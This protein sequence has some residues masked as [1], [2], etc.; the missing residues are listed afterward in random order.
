MMIC[1]EEDCAPSSSPMPVGCVFDD[2]ISSRSSIKAKLYKNKSN[3]TM[4]KARDDIG[5]LCP[6]SLEMPVRLEDEAY[7]TPQNHQRTSPISCS[8]H[9]RD[10]VHYEST[11]Q[12]TIPNR[13]SRSFHSSVSSDVTEEPINDYF[14][15]VADAVVVNDPE[16]YDAELMD[17]EE[18]SSNDETRAPHIYIN[19]MY[20]LP[21]DKSRLKRKGWQDSKF[22][23]TALILIAVSVGCG[24]ITTGVIL[25]LKE[26]AS[27]T[28]TTNNTT[29]SSINSQSTIDNHSQTY[30]VIFSNTT[31]HY[32]IEYKNLTA[33]VGP[34]LPACPNVS[35]VYPDLATARSAF[36]SSTSQY[37]TITNARSTTAGFNSSVIDECL[38]EY[39]EA[40]LGDY[41][42]STL[43][44]VAPNITTISGTI[45]SSTVIDPPPFDIEA[46]CSASNLPG[47]L[48]ACSEA[49][50]PS[51][52]CY[53]DSSNETCIGNSACPLY[54]P[55]CDVIYDATWINGTLGVLK[56]VT[57]EMVSAC[58][59][60]STQPFSERLH[61]HN[62][63]VTEESSRISSTV[64]RLRGHLSQVKVANSLLAGSTEEACQWYCILATCCSAAIVTDPESSGLVLSPSGVFTNASSG[65]YVMTNCQQT[66]MKNLQLCAEYQTFCPQDTETTQVDMVP[67]LVHVSGNDK[68]EHAD[69]LKDL[70][71]KRAGTTLM[72]TPDFTSEL[73]DLCG[74]SLASK[75]V[76]YSFKGDKQ[77]ILH[78]EYELKV[79]GLGESVLSIYTGSCG[80]GSLICY[81]N[82]LADDNRNENNDI[83]IYEFLPEVGETY[84][85]LLSGAN[86]DTAG[87][88]QFR[89]TELEI[90]SNDL[91]ENATKIV[92]VPQIPLILKG[93]TTGA[94][95]DFNIT[96]VGIHGC[97]GMD[98]YTRGLWYQFTGK[99][100]SVRLEYHMY[101]TGLGKSEL[102]IFTGS[103]GDLVCV[104]NVDGEWHYSDYNDMAAYEFFAVENQDYWFLLYGQDFKTVG[105]YEFKV[106][107][108]EVPSNDD[109][110]NATEVAVSQSAPFAKKGLST[111]GATPDFDDSNILTCVVDWY[112][113]GV[114]Y[115][116]IG[117]GAVLR[118]AYQLYSKGTGNSHLAIF[119]GLCQSLSCGVEAGIAG[120]R[121]YSG[122]NDLVV[123]E[124]LAE[125]GETYY[126]WLSGENFNAAATYDFTVSEY[127]IPSNDKCENAT[128]MS[129][130]MLYSGTTAGSTPDFNAF[131]QKCGGSKDNYGVWYSFTGNGKLT[132]FSY[133]PTYDNSQLSLFGGPCDNLICE[134]D[135]ETETSYSFL[136]VRGREYHLFLAGNSFG[137]VGD[138]SL[139]MEQYDRPANDVCVNALEV[140]RVQSTVEGNMKG[141]TQDFNEDTQLCGEDP[142]YSGVWYSFIGTGEEFILELRTAGTPSDFWGEIAVF[143]GQCDKFEC[144]IQDEGQGENAV[145]NVIVPSTEDAQYKVLVASRDLPTYDAPFQF[146]ALSKKPG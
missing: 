28:I 93:D 35:V 87:G 66:N 17:D 89:V 39:F 126:V 117:H 103:C 56:E 136:S 26:S 19:N 6:S 140:T 101:S 128:A 15:I 59:G 125:E 5:E 20:P 12:S 65:E 32:N 94:T 4:V 13:R 8:E 73:E 141:A 24:F 69:S 80:V 29:D 27:N 112:T 139:S 86:G 143:Q 45:L 49:C 132:S 120:G 109:C 48:S 123:H 97:V 40:Y 41:K 58:K 14:E 60:M 145:V 62:N 138:F 53:P 11:V 37:G 72:A 18:A 116:I 129:P 121:H 115:R 64:Y 124:F 30:K 114:W 2:S 122:Y 110:V 36:N 70:P 46:R 61:V 102:S 34:T 99:G 83:A 38:K 84:L 131:N 47:S 55:Y 118:M 137:T 67:A 104:Q 43:S 105:T 71:A 25:G 79:Q 85:F 134:K 31:N 22:S 81:D 119:R 23:F 113:R 130:G 106:T 75:G 146:S 51:A 96:S 1:P 77:A 76:W 42:E 144:I 9:P 92:T 100:T 3:T 21:E 111:L 57:D 52:C 50:L 7:S 88:Y 10:N 133:T 68:C 108:Y 33:D 142:L 16:V 82:V 74:T 63:R 98:W 44:T 107:E 127:G 91:C 78:L 95:P 135:C 54:R 90:P